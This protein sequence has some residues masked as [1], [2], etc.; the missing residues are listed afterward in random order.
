MSGLKAASNIIPSLLG[1]LLFLQPI[2]SIHVTVSSLPANPIDLRMHSK[3]E[4]LVNLT[5]EDCN[6]CYFYVFYQTQ[7]QVYH[8]YYNSPSKIRLVLNKQVSIETDNIGDPRWSWEKIVVTDRIKILKF[9]FEK[10]KIEDTGTY[11]FQMNHQWM[12]QHTYQDVYIRIQGNSSS[13][14]RYF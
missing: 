13:V 8:Y 14:S 9:Y 7:G 5:I 2:S 12:S 4:F 6:N 11:R 10:Q 3:S 1:C